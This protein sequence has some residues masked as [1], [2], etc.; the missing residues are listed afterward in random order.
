[1]V[2]GKLTTPPPVSVA[3]LLAGALVASCGGAPATTDSAAPPSGNF[4]TE[5]ADAAEDEGSL[6]GYGPADTW[7]RIEDVAAFADLL[8][9]NGINLTG[10]EW[11]PSV[12]DRLYLGCTLRDGRFGTLGTYPAEA[13]AWITEMRARNIT[14]L[15]TLNWNECAVWE[16]DDAWFVE[17]VMEP[18]LAIGSERVILAPISEPYAGPD[19]EKSQRWAEIAREMWEGEFAVATEDGSGDVTPRWAHVDFDYVD[20]H[21]CT[22]EQAMDAIGSGQ[23]RL[24]VNTDCTPLLFPDEGTYARLAGTARDAG[25]HFYAYVN[26]FEGDHRPYVEAI[27]EAIGAR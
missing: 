23:E 25:V 26:R 22:E 10:I 7:H 17:N 8:E 16:Q 18:L 21:P 6:V 13:L 5:D 11:V 1:M 3:L 12:Q 24:L 20:S 14:T 15:V 27:G 2:P 19:A 4:V 9:E